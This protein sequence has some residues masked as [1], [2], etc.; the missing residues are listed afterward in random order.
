MGARC[1]SSG[2]VSFLGKYCAMRGLVDCL[3]EIGQRESICLVVWF[4]LVQFSFLSSEK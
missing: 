1:C 4:S 3:F 2:G